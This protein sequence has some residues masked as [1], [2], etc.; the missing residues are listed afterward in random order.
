MK[1]FRAVDIELGRTGVALLVQRGESRL[2]HIREGDSSVGFG[3]G[4]GTQQS[5]VAA[6]SS[7]GD[8]ALHTNACADQIVDRRIVVLAPFC[9]ILEPASLSRRRM[10]DLA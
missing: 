9:A 5:L 1:E 7:W 10:V 4:F 6:N 8:R 3:T 2:T